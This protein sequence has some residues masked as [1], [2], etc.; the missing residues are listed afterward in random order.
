M[1]SYLA[2]IFL[3]FI[4]Q[5]SFANEYNYEH[6]TKTIDLQILSIDTCSFTLESGEYLDGIDDDSTKH[7]TLIN[8]KKKSTNRFNISIRTQYFELV[9]TSQRLLDKYIDLP[10]PAI[11]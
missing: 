6:V 11:A 10:P 1:K 9:K 3:F 8:H 4:S 2:L 7:F 5:L